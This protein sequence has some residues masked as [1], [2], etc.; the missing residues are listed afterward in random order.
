M[1]VFMVQERKEKSWSLYLY[2]SQLT[3]SIV[4]FSQLFQS[5]I[6]ATNECLFYV[7]FRLTEQGSFDVSDFFQLVLHKAPAF[8]PE[9]GGAQ[10]TMQMSR[11]NTNWN[12][13]RTKR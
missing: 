3:G 12:R 5:I 2:V 9:C 7:F 8:A 10:P 4:L 6:I 1:E 13:K 11:N